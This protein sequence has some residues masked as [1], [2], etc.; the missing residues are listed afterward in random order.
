MSYKTYIT[1]TLVCGSRARNTSDKTYLLFTR[2][3]GMLYATAKSVREERSKQRFSLQEF[4]Y[5][6]ATLIHGKSGWRVTGVEPYV[7]VYAEKGTREG[8]TLVR[9]IIRV[10]RR[11]L[12]GETAHPD[13]FDD[14]LLV[15][16]TQEDVHIPAREE[17]LM[18]RM[19]HALGYIAPTPTLEP[20]LTKK[21]VEE[22]IPILESSTTA[23]RQAL[24]DKAFRESHL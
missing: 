7:N 11:L 17:I 14:V 8:R 12:Q 18:L 4:S 3:A 20:L 23:E 19:L 16:T 2:E 6:R 15:L 13:L 21:T 1:D 10:L 22:C 5:I 24:I 9:N